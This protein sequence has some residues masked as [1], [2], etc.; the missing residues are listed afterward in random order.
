M[1]TKKC[2]EWWDPNNYATINP[3]RRLRGCRPASSSL[4]ENWRP[5]TNKS[6]SCR[7]N[8]PSR[9]RSRQLSHPRSWIVRWN[10]FE[11][12]NSWMDWEVRG[13]DGSSNPWSLSSVSSWFLGIW[14]W[15]LEQSPTWVCS[16]VPSES[17]LRNYGRINSNKWEVPYN[18]VIISLW[19]WL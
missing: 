2:R 10:Y 5:S 16:R 13:N 19:R 9:S 3:S 7:I 8:S 18:P 14:F 1:T 6:R 17:S 4:G 12:V 11:P 15:Q